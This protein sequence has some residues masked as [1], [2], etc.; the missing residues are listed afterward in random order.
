[1]GIDGSNIEF[2]R[3]FRLVTQTNRNVFL[4]GRAGTGKT[5]FLKYLRDNSRKS[6]AIVAP[7][8]IAAINAGGMTIHSL[9][10]IP[11][12]FIAPDKEVNYKLKTEKVKLL[13]SIELLI[14]EEVSMV[15][16]DLF[17]MVERTCRA[18]GNKHLPFGGKQILFIGDPYQL[19][20]FVDDSEK[21]VFYRIYNSTFFFKSRLFWQ[22][23]PVPI[24]LKKIYRQNEH[25]FIDLLNKVRVNEINSDDLSLLNSRYIGPNFD[26]SKNGY[27]FL[28]TKNSQ[29][30]EINASELQKLPGQLHTFEG[31][32]SGNF[33]KEKTPTEISLQLKVNAQVMFV[34][35]D[36]SERYY[37]GKIGKIKSISGNI[38]EVSL[39]EGGSV[40][41]SRATWESIVYQWDEKENKV[42]Q[43]VDGTFTQYPLKLAWAITVHKSQGLS[44]E[45]VYADVGNSWSSGQVYVAI[46]RCTTFEGLKL[47]DYIPRHAIKVAAEIQ[48]FYQ[49]I[50]D[51][52]AK[53]DAPP[54]ILFF[55]SDNLVLTSRSEVEISWEVQGASLISINGHNDLPVK[56]SLKILP[57]KELI[58][59]LT[60]TNEFGMES[61]KSIEFKVQ[62]TPPEIQYFETS[63]SIFKDKEPAILSWSVTG[64][65]KVSI[66]GIGDVT[67]KKSISFF[68]PNNCELI[69]TAEGYF[70]TTKQAKLSFTAI[71][72]PPLIDFFEVDY[73]F[74]LKGMQ[75]MLTWQVQNAE[76]V[77][78]EPTGTV[79]IDSNGIYTCIIEEN[80][81]FY[82][83]AWSPFG[84]EARKAVTVQT[85]PVPMI[86]TIVT[87]NIF[88]ESKMQIEINFP[89]KKGIRIENLPGLPLVKLNSEFLQP[90]LLNQSKNSQWP[91]FNLSNVFEQVKLKVVNEFE[92]LIE[93]YKTNKR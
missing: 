85:I 87:P 67:G 91:S 52:T 59:T 63:K 70:G 76:S 65:E 39:P 16:I 34:K 32:I 12:G 14:I 49:W 19:P 79:S 53:Q 66:S 57:R 62:E 18:F 72:T 38:I 23:K 4:T 29:V 48:E 6:M 7:T 69:L 47:A 44:L 88:I 1:M 28:G 8:G 58:Y 74:A 82:L 17:E 30:S 73:P 27:L 2:Q 35:N 21:D 26:F 5:T 68:R 10:Q 84:I 9:F 45:K 83:T 71:K 93:Q 43:K 20:S 37:N 11:L 41:V 90:I 42:I 54:S 33:I 13:Q 55:Q 89:Q 80:T 78:I 61:H 64:A 25:L 40:S 56:G 15:R 50:L 36:T 46:S 24:E 81:S 22:C 31:I 92:K 3:A 51:E 86:E 60:A 75:V 77:K